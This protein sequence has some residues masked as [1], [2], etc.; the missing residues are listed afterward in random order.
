M[1][2]LRRRQNVNISEANLCLCFTAQKKNSLD[3][4]VLFEEVILDSLVLNLGKYGN[5]FM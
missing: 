2:Y 5:C 4:G 3:K 1:R